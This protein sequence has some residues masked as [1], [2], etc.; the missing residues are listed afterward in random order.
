MSGKFVNFAALYAKTRVMGNL[1][2]LGRHAPR[3]FLC[4]EQLILS[5]TI[6]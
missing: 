6:N 4:T 3:A 2:A 1:S 5:N